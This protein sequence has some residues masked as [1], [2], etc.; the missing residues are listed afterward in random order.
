MTASNF[1]ERVSGILLHPTSL[2]GPFGLG[3]L[4]PAA[5]RFAEFLARAGQRYWQMLPVA[6]PGG[7]DSP[8]DSPSAF[9]GSP[10]LVSLELLARDGLLDPSDLTAPRRLADA[11]R[12]L[13]N[14]GRRYRTTRL[15]KAFARFR[16]RPGARGELERYAESEGAWVRDY[17]LFCALKRANAGAPWTRWSR[18]LARREPHALDAARRDLTHDVEF[19]LFVQYEFSRQWRELRQRCSAL[20]V[21]LLGDVPMFV[22]HDASDVW[23]NQR[24]FQLR[25]DGERRMVAGVPPDYFS[26]EGQL[27]GNP[28][29]D[30]QALRESGFDWWISRLKSMLERFDA[31]RLDHFIGFHRFWQIPATSISARDGHFAE[32]PGE[33]FFEKARAVLGALPFI[34]EDLGIMT[35]GVVRLRDRFE[36]PGMRILGFGFAGDWREYQPHRY[37]K[38]CVVYTG[39]HD[40]DTAV[41]WLSAHERETVPE[42]K[43]ALAAESERAL[44]YAA[45][46]GREPH[47][48]MIRLALSSVANTAIFPIQDL[49]GQGSEHRMNV[50]GTAS[51]NW[52]YRVPAAALTPD[53][54]QRMAELCERY[55]RMPPG[56]RRGT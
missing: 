27:W 40:N 39:T 49:L 52:R 4:G 18:D 42:R 23:A 7:G 16:D 47:W 38:N 14:A 3:D 35:E 13:F 44:R 34:A 30:W 53:I 25:E 8:Y 1:S 48:D 28:L 10:L 12:A 54:A 36:L 32:A 24:C 43:R 15:K 55:E 11:P 2:P 29:Y 37:P 51:G 50:P 56:L 6:P 21:R 41:G 45:S 5:H 26:E 20:G 31:V 46:D 19:E 9:A 33:E 22:A 17:A